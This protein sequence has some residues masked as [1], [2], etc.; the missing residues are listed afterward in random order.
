[1]VIIET[2]HIDA[3]F[4]HQVILLLSIVKCL[5]LGSTAA[6]L[7]DFRCKSEVFVLLKYGAA[8]LGDRRS[9]FRD[10]YTSRL[11]TI[12]GETAMVLRKRHPV[13]QCHIRQE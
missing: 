4:K 8:S 12:E 2:G 7:D 13:A 5:S 3:R 11:S 9:I 10:T 1:M 6:I